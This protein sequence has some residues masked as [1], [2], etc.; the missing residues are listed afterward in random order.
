MAIATEVLST[1][2]KGLKS[3]GLKS[4]RSI[5]GCVRIFLCISALL[6]PGL[7]PGC[8]RPSQCLQ[9]SSR[10][11]PVGESLGSRD[12]LPAVLTTAEKHK[13]SISAHVTGVKDIN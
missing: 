9:A 8:C 4:R 1:G 7:W 6:V 13:K 5:R 2:L 10:R 11:R 12:S 3:Q